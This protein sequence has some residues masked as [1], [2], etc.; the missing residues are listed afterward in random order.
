MAQDTQPRLLTR[1]DAAEYCAITPSQFSNWVKDGL[2]PR[3]LHGT[4]RWDKRAIDRKLDELSGIMAQSE[5]SPLEQ[6]KA[7]LNARNT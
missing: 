7:K 4:Q 1:H 2:M 6:Y 3:A 5:L